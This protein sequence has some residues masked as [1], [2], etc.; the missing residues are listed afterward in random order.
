MAFPAVAATA[1]T[2]G[3]TA[4]INK[5][6][7][8]PANIVAGQL[9]LLLLRSAAADTHSTPSGWTQLI[10]NN[11][12]DASLD[13]FSLW[14][15]VAAGNEGATVTVTATTSLKF[16]ALAWRITNAE[17]PGIIAPQ[18]STVAVGTSTTPDP[19]SITPSGGAKDYLFMW[20]GCWEGEQT[21]P[22][23]SNPTNYAGNKIGC[24][25]GTGGT[26]DTNVRCASATRN[27]NTASAEDAGSWTISVSDDW[28]AITVIIHPIDAVV[29]ETTTHVVS[30]RSARLRRVPE[31]PH[32]RTLI[33]AASLVE[34]EAATFATSLSATVSLAAALTTEIRAA[35]SLSATGT[36]SPA[37]LADTTLATSLVASGSLLADLLTVAG[38]SRRQA[39]HIITRSLRQRPERRIDHT[40]LIVVAY[41]TPALNELAAALTASGSLAAALTTD[42]RMASGMTATAVIVPDLKLVQTFA[43]SL[44]ATGSLSAALTTDIRMAAAM[45]ASVTTT[46]SLAATITMAAQLLGSGNVLSAL[47]TEIRLATSLLGTAQLSPS[48]LTGGDLATSLV[49]STVLSPSLMTDIRLQAALQAAGLVSANLTTD[50]RLQAALQAFGLV[51]SAIQTDL[52]L[53]ASLLAAASV[54][55][56]L[57]L[58]QLF[59]TLLVASATVQES[60]GYGY[61]VGGDATGRGVAGGEHGLPADFAATLTA[62]AALQ[63]TLSDHPIGVGSLAAMLSVMPDFSAALAAV[64]DLAARLSVQPDKSGDPTVR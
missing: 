58:A 45:S 54:S 37:L 1:T 48:L 31:K 51:S 17:L 53:A 50:I 56:D 27:L 57:K 15:K 62:S 29:A 13:V 32:H 26:V 10:L 34:Q 21:S 38:V 33:R 12:A 22:P 49:G 59:A 46:A 64:P 25:S 23:A 40:P 9:L 14:Y 60:V 44:L 63:A 19:P 55:P 47:L 52:R 35:T 7:N 16:G 2:N 6:C 36:L 20:I 43:T 5:V 39:I 41:Q 28:S 61:F 3:S 11:S 42:I 18:V 4:A 8:L 30:K 24:D